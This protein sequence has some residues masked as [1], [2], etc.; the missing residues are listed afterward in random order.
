M[1]Q[2]WLHIGSPKTGTTSL[3]G[4]LNDNQERLRDEAR[5]N[6]MQAGR[7]HIAHN[8][9]ASAAR[10]G[11][12][13]KLFE[14]I[15]A[16][17]D[18]DPDAQHVMSSE[19]LFNPFTTRK[20]TQSV[21]DSLKGG[22]TKV[23]CYIRRQD[24]YLEALYKQF[25]KNSRIDPDRQAF[26]ADAHRL[27]RY[28]DVINAY[29]RAFGPENI[30]L[31]PFSPNRL[32]GGDI[33]LDFAETLSIQIK[34][35]MILNK[36][37]ANKTFS[38]EMSETLA[39]LSEVTDFNTRE[40][41]REL[42]A[43]DHPGTIKSRDV[44]TNAER[45][46]LM[47]AMTPENRKLVRRYMPDHADFFDYSDLEVTDEVKKDEQAEQL[48]DRAA[49]TEAILK[50]IGNLQ[51]RRK[52]EAEL[53][54]EPKTAPEP[55]SELDAEYAP[56]SWYREIYPAGARD[57]WFRKFGDYSC[58]FVERDRAQL[59]VSFDN[60][61]QAGNDAFAREPW[62][63]KFCE[64]R[65]YSHLG[66]YAQSPTWFRDTALIDYLEQLRD[67]GF[68]KG[69]KRVSFVGTSMGAF[70]A[71][72][73]SSLAPGSTV[74]AFSP[75]TTLDAQEVPWET[76]FGKG[77]SA[78]W[79]LPYSDA[80]LE[81][82]TAKRVYLIY[83]PFHQGDKKHIERL[84]G[85][86]LIHLKGFGIGHK[87][88]LVLNRINVLKQVMEHGIAGDLDPAQFYKWLRGRKDI[89]LYRQSMEGYLEAR[90]QEARIKKFGDAF[91]K[92]RRLQNA[93]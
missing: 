92:R 11:E 40:V 49:A 16:E 76:R 9:L 70:G 61:S 13:T 38:A 10:M 47:D 58:S 46:S 27:V 22:R 48:Q 45:R 29:G 86:N 90:G 21:P 17:V 50:A 20:F 68:F 62:A 30:L 36:G 60:L 44:F 56:P 55:A 53:A 71:L 37:F 82:V 54:P 59:V 31:R 8:Q 5:V 66:V 52:Q 65:S 81:T 63:Q 88:A 78:D 89:Y 34:K 33:V 25:L 19:L 2:I 51:R 35:G 28:F 80:A 43:I 6:F 67:E 84:E 4:F 69:F 41:I 18:A 77:R 91:K 87:S 12:T 57:G 64:D 85:G 93:T 32:K 14:Q 83:D 73:F 75:Q 3:Q 1:G 24:T 23:I 7:S 79:S 72:T 39:T 15:E 74:V 26:L 42:I